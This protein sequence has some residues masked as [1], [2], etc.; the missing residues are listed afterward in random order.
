MEAFRRI[1]LFVHVVGLAFGLFMAVVAFDSVVTNFA[2]DY[3]NVALSRIATATSVTAVAVSFCLLLPLRGFTPVA[4]ALF[5][6]SFAIVAFMVQAN[7]RAMA[8]SFA[9]ADPSEFGFLYGM[10]IAQILFAFAV[11]VSAWLWTYRH[12]RHPIL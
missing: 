1:A 12:S 9:P 8:K 2:T 4:P 3:W 6:I 10:A 11:A 7:G 5:A